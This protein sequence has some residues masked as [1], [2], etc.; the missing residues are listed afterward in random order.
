MTQNEIVVKQNET[1]ESYF[2]QLIFV[3]A[4]G[5]STIALTIMLQTISGASALVFVAFAP[6]VWYYFKYYK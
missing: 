5:Y 2:K 6:L 1:V 4:L 3:K